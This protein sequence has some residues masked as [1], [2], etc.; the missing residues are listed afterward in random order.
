MSALRTTSRGE[1]YGMETG[2]IRRDP[3]S[4]R[5]PLWMAPGAYEARLKVEFSTGEVQQDALAIHVMAPHPAL[6]PGGTIALYDPKGET[7][8]LLEGIGLRYRKVE[9]GADLSG[10]D[11]LII[12]KGALSASGP[13]PDLRR[14]PEG[15]KVI[16]FE[17]TREA[18][19]RRLDFRVQEYGLRQVFPRVQGHPALE[20]IGAENLRDWRGAATILP[21][22]LKMEKDPRLGATVKWCDIT[23][24]RLWRCGNHGNVASVLIEKPACG[25]FLPLVDGGFSLQYSPLMEY[26]EGTGL[27]VF[28][29]MDVT[30]RTEDDPAGE[31]LVRNLLNYVREWKPAPVRKVVYAGDPAGKTHL[32]QAG[33]APASYAGGRLAEDQVLVVGPGGGMQVAAHAAALGEWLKAG[34]RL[35]ALGLDAGEANAFLPWKITTQ[36]REHIAAFFEPVAAGSLLA[37]GG[38][39]DVHN[40]APRELPLITGGAVALGDGVLACAKD[41]HVAFCQILPWT[42]DAKNQGQKRTFRRTSYLVSRLLGNMGAAGATPLLDRFGSPVA[43]S[44]DDTR[45]WLHGLYLDEPEEWDDPYRAFRW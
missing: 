36:S 10:D 15:L 45:R 37:G 8:K 24:T 16:I 4:I 31:R 13:G 38:P 43:A 20:G 11:L 6:R 42:F 23:V 44:G 34:G 41:G 1:T 35:L 40:R 26:R 19:A 22:R 14:V 18:L 7:A 33:F 21:P 28:C 29:Q 30:G 25:N 5:V 39:A 32:D 3:V 12:G 2:E 9:A 17:Q 27:V